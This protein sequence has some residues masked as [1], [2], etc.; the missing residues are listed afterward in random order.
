MRF[1]AVA[2]W[3]DAWFYGRYGSNFISHGDFQWN[4]GSRAYGL[5]APL[6]GVLVMVGQWMGIQT[7]LVLWGLA[8][9]FGVLALGLMIWKIHRF[10]DD[11]GSQRR[12]LRDLGILAIAM[13]ASALASHMSSGMETTFAMAYLLAYLLLVNG[14][15][16]RMSSGK[17]FAIGIMGGLAWVIRPELMLFTWGIPFGLLLFGKKGTQRREAIYAFLFT[18]ASTLAAVWACMQ[19]F[20]GLLPLSFH[21]KSLGAQ[22]PALLAEFRFHGWLY[23]GTFLLMNLLPLGLLVLAAIKGRRKWWT[24]MHVHERLMLAGLLLFLGYETV[25]VLPVMGYDSRFLYPAWPVLMWLGTRSTLFLLRTESKFKEILLVGSRRW[26]VQLALLLP[27]VGLGTWHTFNTRLAGA[28]AGFAKFGVEVAYMGVGHGNWPML[29]EMNTLGDT[30]TA[31]GTELGILGM[32]RPNSEVLDLG[33]LQDPLT[34]HEGFSAARLFTEQK[35]DL[36]Y[37]PLPPY[38]MLR[39]EILNWAQNHDDYQY[40]RFEDAFVDVLVRRDSPVMGLASALGKASPI[41]Y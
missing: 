16:H 29:Q 4:P 27:V 35:P 8:F 1:S 11:G 17:A 31:A 18:S 9:L 6:Y 25:F 20:G 36:V 24:F 39:K 7:G 3:D 10:G 41:E 23:L 14:F 37:L 28:K 19:Q 32:M 13:N 40:F 30:I 5:T 34:A 15:A 33:G 26:L 22:D 12:I 2:V 21:A 38:G